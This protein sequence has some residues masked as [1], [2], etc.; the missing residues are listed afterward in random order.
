MNASLNTFVASSIDAASSAL[1]FSFRE[2]ALAI[3][4]PK[5]EASTICISTSGVHCTD[6]VSFQF[7]PL[8]PESSISAK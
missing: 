4:S 8:C 2:Q 3:E 5:S 1:S 6:H 7:M